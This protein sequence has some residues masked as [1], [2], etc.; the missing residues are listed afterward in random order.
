MFTR[1][2][3]LTMSRWFNRVEGFTTLFRSS[4]FSLP[5]VPVAICVRNSLH[6]L[7][8][9]ILIVAVAIVVSYFITYICTCTLTHV[10]VFSLSL[11]LFLLVSFFLFPILCLAAAS[12]IVATGC[13]VDE[14]S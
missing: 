11:S 10:F 13:R 2:H 14:R 3:L 12:L 8:I 5:S 6:I 7:I 9:F 1:V 4:S